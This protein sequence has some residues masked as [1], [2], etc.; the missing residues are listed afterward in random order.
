MS[1]ITPFDYQGQVVAFN[2][3]GWINATDAAERFG[4]RP[5]DWLRLPATISYMGAMA[6]AL[7]IDSKVGKS[8]FGLA[9][10]SRGGTAPGTWL[11]P[12]LAVAFARW[13]SDDFAAWCDLKIDALL[14]RE[15]KPWASARREASIG[16]RALCDALSMSRKVS[17]KPTMPYH[18]ANEARLINEVIAGT[19]AGRNRDQLDV[20]ELELIALAETRDAVLIGMGLDFAARR[21]NLIGY[22]QTLMG[23]KNLR[24]AAA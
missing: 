21:Q 1:K 22:M 6:R 24:S 16:Y 3:D 11:H 8:H 4:K 5:V 20:V 10:T 12:K 18:Y 19:F 23:Q 15:S 13:L 9:R 7:R 14:R 17:G 2:A